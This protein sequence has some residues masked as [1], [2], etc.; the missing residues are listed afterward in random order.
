MD[1]ALFPKLKVGGLVANPQKGDTTSQPSV[2]KIVEE[3]M[4]KIP[5]R[6]PKG[7]PDYYQTSMYA[8]R[9][10]FLCQG[11]DGYDQ[12]GEEVN[13]DPVGSPKAERPKVINREITDPS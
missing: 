7:W 11:K 8:S 1:F 6:S 2:V 13:A 4:F 3:K 10:L 9:V 12:I 5:L